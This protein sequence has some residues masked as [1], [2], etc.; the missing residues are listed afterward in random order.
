MQTPLLRKTIDPVLRRTS[1]AFE[2]LL[3]LQ[4]GGL[5]QEAVSVGP[6]FV[7]V[8]QVAKRRASEQ[9]S[10]PEQE[11]QKLLGLGLHDRR[12]PYRNGSTTFCCTCNK[13]LSLSCSVWAD[14]YSTRYHRQIRIS[15]I[16][17]QPAEGFSFIIAG[18]TIG[19][20]EVGVVGGKLLEVFAGVWKV[21]EEAEAKFAGRFL[22]AE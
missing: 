22:R 11:V 17:P 15:K 4:G 6:T 20:G 10:G 14:S 9:L 8:S 19:E 1:V 12:V 18:Q 21:A 16:L 13:R 7:G 2:P 5:S 3:P